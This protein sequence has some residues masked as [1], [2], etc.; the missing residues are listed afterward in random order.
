MWNTLKTAALLAV[1]TSLTM[2]VG[3]AIGGQRGLVFGLFFAGI[4]NFV[5]WWFSDKIVLAMHG[6][7]QVGPEDAP[8]LYAIVADLARR[9]GI[10]TPRLYII[11]QAAPNAFATGRSPSHAAVACTEGILRAMPEDELRGVLA[12]EL[13]HVVHRDT[14]ISTIAAT[15]AGAI[16]ILSRQALWWGGGRRRD[17]GGNGLLALAALI[18]APM[19]AM[20]I[21]LAVSRSREYAADEFSARL[22]GD[23]EPLI[24]ALQ[25]IEGAAARGFVMPANN[26][27]AHLYISNPGRTMMSI[28]R[29]HPLTE[30]RIARLREVDAELHR[31]R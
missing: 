29:T 10:P 11:P 15:M 30:E 24:R 6:A 27:T 23:A 21:Q 7:R 19:A 17:N 13:G 1:M 8:E 3:E 31:I 9:A 14:L 20:V 26:A 12:H 18:F 5:S 28:F 25:R 4:M 2:L 16:S 22:V